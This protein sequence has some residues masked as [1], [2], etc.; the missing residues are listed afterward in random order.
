MSCAGK[1]VDRP[2]S[3]PLRAVPHTTTLRCERHL[4]KAEV[5]EDS[6]KAA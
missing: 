5:L 6:P 3:W 4:Y 1:P 2:E